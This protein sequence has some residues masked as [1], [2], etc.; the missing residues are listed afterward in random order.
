M[1]RVQWLEQSVKGDIYYIYIYIYI[2]IFY[3]VACVRVCI[4][5]DTTLR[6]K[7]L[8]YNEL[9]YFFYER[10]Y[11]LHFLSHVFLFFYLCCFLI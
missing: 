4:K 5:Y 1:Q 3:T 6:R 9:L 11:F 10:I 7:I 8:I 2:K